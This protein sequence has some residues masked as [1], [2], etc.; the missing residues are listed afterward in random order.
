MKKGSDNYRSSSILDVID[1]VIAAGRKVIIFEPNI[2]N[3]FFNGIE[4][5]NDFES[6]KQRADL[7][8]TNRQDDALSDIQDKVFTRDIFKEN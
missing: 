7:V 6:F 2:N 8:V 3:K 1:L 4:I 5:D